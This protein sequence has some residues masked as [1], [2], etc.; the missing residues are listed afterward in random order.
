MSKAIQIE[1]TPFVFSLLAVKPSKSGV[2]PRARDEAYMVRSLEL[3]R[4][5]EFLSVT[6]FGI[7]SGD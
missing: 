7:P 4:F 6:S 2:D 3:V 1:D 5:F